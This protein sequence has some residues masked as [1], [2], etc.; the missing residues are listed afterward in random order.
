MFHSTHKCNQA[1]SARAA[2]LCAAA[3]VAL[4]K[5]VSLPRVTV[6]VDG[7]LFKFHSRFHDLLKEKV[8]QLLVSSGTQAELVLA[9]DGNG[10]G[11]ALVAAVAER[12]RA[13]SSAKEHEPMQL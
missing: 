4:L 1:V 5:R 3:L 7:S 2:H 10:K 13:D 8:N 9:G 6:G 12:I 11:A